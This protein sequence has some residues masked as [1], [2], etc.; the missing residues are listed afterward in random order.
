MLK[1]KNISVLSVCFFLTTLSVCAQTYIFRKPPPKD[2]HHRLSLNTRLLLDVNV[3]VK[4]LGNVGYPVIDDES[5]IL[6]FS[7]GYITVPSD[8][9]WENGDG[10]IYV[11]EFGFEW[12]NAYPVTDGTNTYVD[13]FDLTRYRSVSNGDSYSGDVSS[14]GWELTYDYRWG[15][16]TD[17]F[18]YGVMAGIGINNVDYSEARRV[19]TT[20]IVQ[21]INLKIHNPTDNGITWVNSDSGETGDEGAIVDPSILYGGDSA[22]VTLD[23]DEVE[24]L[25]EEL[26]FPSEIY[27][28]IDEEAGSTNPAYSPFRLDGMLLTGRI[29]GNLSYNIT[30]R[31]SLELNAG[32][33]GA[34]FS[35]TVSLR[36][37]LLAITNRTSSSV[38]V[39]DSVEDSDFYLGYFVEGLLR[40]QANRRTSFY[41]GFTHVNMF[42]SPEGTVAGVPYEIDMESPKFASAGMTIHF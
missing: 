12:E 30:N 19:N 38:S 27:E 15:K 36:N 4:N 3:K 29:G 35:S 40:F 11:K 9:E 8:Q 5:N 41:G 18:R 34:Y 17:R 25:R 13:S 10:K 7:D 42:D 23:P 22:E 16:N 33:I 14:I 21:T 28:S 32:I 1:L 31:L 26:L 20:I 6:A 39:Y 37:T 2:Q 24:D